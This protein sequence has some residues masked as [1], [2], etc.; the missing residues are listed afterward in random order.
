[1]LGDEFAHEW[2]VRDDGE[3][4]LARVIQGVPDKRAAETLTGKRASTIVCTKA[5]S[6]GVTVCPLG[7]AYCVN[8]AGSPSTQIS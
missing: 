3:A 4:F 5:I 6:P 1:M 2:A 8:P 7:V